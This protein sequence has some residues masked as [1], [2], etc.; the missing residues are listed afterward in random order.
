MALRFEAPRHVDRQLARAPGR[1]RLEEVDGLAFRAEHQV[2]V[3]DE[4]GGREA[5]VEL[6]QIELVRADAR[7]LVGLLGGHARQRVH[8]REDL[9]GL[10]IGIGSQDRRRDLD[11]APL[12]LEGERAQLRV[13]DDDRRRRAVAV[14]RAHRP[15]VGVGDHD[16]A[17][18][19]LERHALRVGRERVQ[20]RVGVVLLRD[21]GEELEVGAAVA[22]AV[23]HAD[24]GE[25]A[26]HRVRADAAVDRGDGAVA[27][28]ALPAVAVLLAHSAREKS[29]ARELLDADR[30]A[31]VRFTRFHGQVRHAQGRRPRRAGVR[32]VVGR[33][34]GL[35]DLLLDLLGDRSRAAHQVARREHTHVLHRDAAVGEGA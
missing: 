8:V 32:D 28:R 19:L 31:E 12:L 35:A 33:D 11:R 5:I 7:L 6:H 27:A 1:P 10:L 13:A 14:G 2:V 17:H 9:T 4:L 18:D 30:E 29:G 16:V 3:V 21:L 23:L 15:R 22:V 24:L 34:A 26:R 20:G 25:H